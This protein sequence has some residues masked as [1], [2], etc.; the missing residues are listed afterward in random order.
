M[1]NQANPLD[2]LPN[3]E[4]DS[5]QIMAQE[6]QPPTAQQELAQI[7]APMYQVE[8]QY[9]MMVES[10]INLVYK[11]LIEKNAIIMTQS[12]EIAELK[13]KLKAIPSSS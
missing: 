13:E 12:K 4:Q 10:T 6:M 8:K 1:S 7:K 11:Q 9:Q 2:N 5:D 3:I